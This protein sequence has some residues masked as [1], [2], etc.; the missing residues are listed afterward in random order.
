[1][2]M[3]GNLQQMCL[4]EIEINKRQGDKMTIWY[5][6][7]KDNRKDGLC[8]AD[9]ELKFRICKEKSMLGIGWGLNACFPSWNAYRE[10]ADLYY[11]NDKGYAAAVNA[12]EKIA[13]GDLVWV[14]QPAKHTWYLAQVTDDKPSL[15][16]YLR[17]FDLY[18]YR[19]A[20]FYRI[21]EDQLNRFCLSQEKR[22]GR[23]TI[24]KAKSQSVIDATWNLLQTIKPTQSK[25]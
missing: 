18:G 10:L 13:C 2:T 24:E 14:Q 9:E 17:E 25:G 21:D 22:S 11:E 23:H 19:K 6:N 16:C 4:A 20:E 3:D 1:M 15:C 8:N 7:L 5:M 12:L